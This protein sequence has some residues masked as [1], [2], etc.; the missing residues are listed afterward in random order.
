M[1]ALVTGG[2]GFIGSNFVRLLLAERPET[3][4][5]NLDLLT[6]AGNLQ[7]LEDIL[8]HPRHHFV[9]ADI[10]DAEGLAESLDG[11]FDLIVNFAA[12]S[13]VD[14]SIDS[15]AEFIRTN[16]QGT[17]CLLDLARA[18]G[19]GRFLQVSTDEVYGSLGAEGLFHEEMPLDPT[20]PYSASK[21][22]ADLLVL[23][24]GKTHGMEVITT[25]CS[26]NYGPQQFPEKLIPL[27]VLNAMEDKELPVYGDGGNIRD[28]IHVED[29]CRAVLTVAEKGETGR[30]YNVG[31][32][33]EQ[34]NIDV[35]REILRI[36]GKPDSLI[37]FV[38]DRPA[39][40]RRY[41]MDAQR[42]KTELGWT[43]QHT[44]ASGLESTVRW[45]QENMA[46]CH[47]V[48]SGAYLDFYDRWYGDRLGVTGTE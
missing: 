1:R 20:N 40:D 4:V 26:N 2:A 17:Q 31:A 47:E 44:F 21:A 42:L 23:A 16:V 37:R 25:R 3:D 38:T 15:A 10:A 7:S 39:H 36:T 8:E 46:W 14:R 34:K 43:P 33:S 18:R 9:K 30:I 41:A 12:E 29:H 24:A 35:V 11:H 27:M 5:V 28:W 32:D 6:Y 22:A 45:Y 13:H 48:R 19:W